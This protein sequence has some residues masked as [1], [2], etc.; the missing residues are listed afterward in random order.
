MNSDFNMKG[1]CI[2]MGR[3]GMRC[4]LITVF[5]VVCLFISTSLRVYASETE[6]NGEK[7][8]YQTV[9]YVFADEDEKAE[10]THLLFAKL[11]YDNLDG[12]EG[13]T[14]KEYIED[15]PEMYN[16]EI[17]SNSGITY[18]A[19]YNSLIGDWNIVEVFNKNDSSGFYGVAFEKDGQAILA[20]RGSEMFTE[21]FAL[22]ESNDWL[23]TDFKFAIFNSLSAQFAD[24]RATYISITKD[25][26]RKGLDLEN[27]TLSG[28]SLGGALVTYVSLLEGA[29][30]Y[31]FDGA[32]GHV[33]DL[34]YYNEYMSIDD[35][36]G[37]D[38]SSNVKY[39]NYTDET[40]YK[41]ADLIQ[42]TNAQYI[43]QIDRVTNVD[44]LIEND[45]IPQIADAASH[46]IWSTLD[47]EGNK[48]FFTEKV[49]EDGY[50]YQPEKTAIIDINRNVLQASIEE[51]GIDSVQDFRDGI[52]YEYIFGAL[53]GVVKEGRVVLCNKSHAVQAVYDGVGVSS[54]FALENV[55]YTGKGDDYI[56]GYVAD[57]VFI[58]GSFKDYYYGS[59]GND[60]YVID[61]WEKGFSHIYDIG[62]EKTIIILR[63]MQIRDIDKI[64]WLDAVNAFEL[65]N[66]N[67]IS[68]NVAQS[69][70]N[71]EFYA[72]DRGKLFYLGTLADTACPKVG[73]SDAIYEFSQEY[74][75]EKNIVMIEGYAT[76]D[77]YDE[78][79]IKVDSITNEDFNG[80]GAVDVIGGQAIVQDGEENP[81]ILLVMTNGYNVKIT[82]DS[83]RC[84]MSV[85]AYRDD[86]GIV[87]CKKHYYKKYKNHLVNFD[88]IDYTDSNSGDVDWL[89]I[90]NQGF[91]IISDWL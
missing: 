63:N 57:D 49:N 62:G 39:C 50:T 61:N 75:Q 89:D 18:K 24:A 10:M 55:I 15:F 66:G 4:K 2:Y 42:H 72:Y 68:I 47:Y 59:L 7:S 20:Y 51:L 56:Y 74:M 54:G 90:F 14:I 6:E 70:E 82:T 86:E 3:T 35:Y 73:A 45:F 16:T 76:I 53:T 22:D 12:Y 44:G 8:Y 46:I 34:I 28:H 31:S 80:T 38:D 40:G 27:I 87:G 23:G 26:R 30:G 13:C 41:V 5:L 25:M 81:S 43:Y 65:P 60:T 69:Y 84:N 83:E 9:E 91:S 58:G 36:T 32:S 71:V 29:Y 88:D 79:D 17:W 64:K 78:N 85:G 77:I 11:V 1:R 21:E 48:V 52:D 67:N 33:I 19:L 37:I